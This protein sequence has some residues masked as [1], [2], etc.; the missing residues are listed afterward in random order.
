MFKV[1]KL[2]RLNENF[3]LYEMISIEGGY[4]WC[5]NDGLIITECN[6]HS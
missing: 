2:H 1:K 6:G 5:K 3:L 4:F